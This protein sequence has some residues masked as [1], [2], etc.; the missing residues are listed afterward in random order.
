M[1]IE[2]AQYANLTKILNE[3]KI[4][5]GTNLNSADQISNGATVIQT[6]KVIEMV[7]G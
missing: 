1:L 6:V 2:I 5:H 4:D 3:K 7:I